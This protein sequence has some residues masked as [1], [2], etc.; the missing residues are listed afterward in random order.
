VDYLS[1]TDLFLVGLALDISGAILLAKGLLLSP[2]MLA[3]LNTV[4]G[5]GEGLHEDRL[6]N[7]VDGEFG[8]GYL[9]CGFIL[10]AVGYSLDIGGVSSKTGHDRLIA[11]LAMAAA[12]AAV[13]WVAWMLL[14]KR[15]TTTLAAKVE[16][17]HQAAA[18]EINEAE[19]ARGDAAAEDDS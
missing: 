13:A 1:L 14:H 17:A 9:V 10:Q 15:R 7:R 19:K 11:A 2:H 8:V 6:R 16:R 18:K 3:S 12:A 5:V 4:W